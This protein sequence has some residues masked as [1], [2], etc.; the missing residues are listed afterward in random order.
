MINNDDL[1]EIFIFAEKLV[2]KGGH[3]LRDGFIKRK[4]DYIRK[5]AFYDLVTIYDKQIEDMFVNGIKEKYPNHLFIGE[6]ECAESKKT[7]ELTNKPT[8]II[9]PIDGTTNFIKKIPHCCISVALTINKE[10]LIGIVF[11]PISNEIF[12][13]TKG[14]GAFLNGEPISVNKNIKAIPDALIGME[15]SLIHCEKVRDKNIKRLYKIGSKATGTRSFGS[16]ALGLCYVAAG[17]IDV[18]LVDDLKPWDMAAGALIATEAG[19][20][21]TNPKGK[22]FQVMRP[23]VVCASSA[24]LSNAACNLIQQAEEMVEFTF[25]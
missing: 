23:D 9:D 14:K 8:W 21:L 12:T 1:T 11:N 16:A 19:A 6:E 25:T 24:E 18:Y 17:Q 5:D 2:L 10:L 3:I 20:I 4:M 7:P 13:A 22:D 15:I